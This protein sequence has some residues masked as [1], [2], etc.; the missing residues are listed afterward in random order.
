MQVCVWQFMCSWVGFVMKRSHREMPER[1]QQHVTNTFKGH[2]TD[3]MRGRL[4]H[5]TEH[6]SFLIRSNKQIN[7]GRACKGAVVM[8]RASLLLTFSILAAQSKVG[9]WRKCSRRSLGL[10]RAAAPFST[11]SLHSLLWD[12]E[13]TAVPGESPTPSR[14][15]SPLLVAYMRKRARFRF[16][17]WPEHGSA[18]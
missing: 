13:I 15:R 18:R 1:P 4:L 9:R 14:S 17:L 6:N 12:N 10:P 2:T 8:T 11:S 3:R 7:E 16:P 5:S